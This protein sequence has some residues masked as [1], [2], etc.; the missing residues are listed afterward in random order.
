[1]TSC[2]TKKEENLNFTETGFHSGHFPCGIT[3][4]PTS[5][6]HCLRHPDLSE[7][8]MYACI[9]CIDSNIDPILPD[10]NTEVLLPLQGFSEMRR[11]YTEESTWHP[12]RELFD[13][14]SVPN[15]LAEHYMGGA[16]KGMI[17]R[18]SEGIRPGKFVMFPS[19]ALHRSLHVGKNK[20]KTALKFDIWLHNAP[21]AW[22]E[23]PQRLDRNWKRRI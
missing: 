9:Y 23:F 19:N 3:N 17:H 18:F 20:F 12:T 16:R 10:G 5:T 1:M 6:A 14:T 21:T 15:K 4:T 7:W 8:Q 2:S 22:E 13:N 11:H